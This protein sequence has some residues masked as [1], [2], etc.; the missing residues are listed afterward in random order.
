MSRTLRRLSLL[1]AALAAGWLAPAACRAALDVDTLL[2]SL[3]RP[4]PAMTPFVEVRYSK[5]LD[6]PLIAKG[7]LEYRGDG[8]GGSTLVREVQSPFRERTE[9]RGETVSI[10]RAGKPPRRFSL[11]RAPEL[12][13]LLAGF[14][15]VLGGSRASLEQDFHLTLA[16]ETGHWT[17]TLTPRS[18]RV[19][20]HVRD[21]LVKGHGDEPRC[22]VVTQPEKPSS[23][24]LLGQVAGVALP[25]AVDR[26][27]LERL[28]GPGG[29]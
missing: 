19:G 20:K 16:G 18:D 2:Q 10:Q 3:A 27:W 4:A 7:V 22:I 15:A 28:C 14:T 29:E 5:L 1:G 17:L 6:R 12:R 24:M 8:T 9:I 25:P 11:K 13:S 26:A 23:V 21:I